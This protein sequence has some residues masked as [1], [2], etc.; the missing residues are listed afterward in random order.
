MHLLKI[1]H[2]YPPHYSAGS[3]VYS[4]SICEE[5]VARGHR[6][7]V[8]T[9]EERPYAVDFRL[10][11]ERVQENFQLYYLNMPRGKDGYRHS[12]IDAQIAALIAQE[13]P[14]VAHIGHLNHLSTGLVEVLHRASIPIVFTLH[15]FWLMCPRGQFLQRNFD[16]EQTYQLCSGQND[17]KC[18]TQ[19]YRMYFSGQADCYDQDVAYWSAWIA[20]RMAETRQLANY[21]DQFIAPSRQLQ[22]RFINDFGLP[23]EKVRYLD[24]GFPT[25]YLHP[26]A[27]HPQKDTF[28]FGYIG[29]LIPAKGV[30]LLIQAFSR[31]QGRARLKIWG[32]KDDQSRKA[33]LAMAEASNNTIEFCGAYRNEDLRETVFQHLDA[34]VVPS[35][36]VENS[37]LVIHEAQAC[38]LP[39]ITGNAGGMAEYVQHQVNGLLF[40]HRS[41]DDLQVQLQWALE[42]PDAMRQLGQRGYLYD[43]DGHIPTITDHC[44]TLETIYQHVQSNSVI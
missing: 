23:P 40:Q 19:C 41:S 44:H 15:D 25:Q 13:L 10:R 42:H 16:G 8:L 33:L 5:L 38:R 20:R 28:T 3:E 29:T 27:P 9:R 22:Q 39:V 4:Q 1:I 6:V 24:Y 35:I 37:P 14:D 7:T 43:A 11:H 30:N 18:A 32:A 12:E 17:H 34:L 36:W 21:V 31:L 2:G 26:I